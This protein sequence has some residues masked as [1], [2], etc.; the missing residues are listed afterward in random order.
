MNPRFGNLDVVPALSRPDLLAE[1]TMEVIK[2]LS[3]PTDFGVAEIDPAF[4]D[5]AAFCERYRVE[6]S[7]A[8]NC[9]VIKATRGDRTWF[10][11]CMVL[12]TMKA[13][14]NGLARRHLDARKASFAPMEEAVS[15]TNMEYGGITP[16]GLPTDWSVLIDKAVAGSERLIIGSGIRKSKIIV[17]GKTL[18]TFPNA[19]VLEGLGFKK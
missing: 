5:T 1:P 7:Q 10:A 19:V 17:S 8:A 6:P 13:D 2:R 9:V 11:A 14:V 3:N 16:I 18:A 4:S 12:R 15:E